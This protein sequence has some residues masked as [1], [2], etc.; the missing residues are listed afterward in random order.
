MLQTLLDPLG[1]LDLA[2]AR[3]ELDRA[4]L[5]HVHA[6]RIGRAA[7]LGIE[8]RRSGFGFLLDVLGGHGGR[9]FGHQ[10]RLG[11]GGLVVDLDAHVADHRD[12]AL[13]LLGVEDVVGQVVVD[14]GVRQVAALLAEHDQRL[15][16]ALARLDVGRR[17]LARRNLGVLAVAALL[18]RG[19]F[20]ALAG[21]PRG[22]LAGG[23]LARRRS[24]GRLR[25]CGGI[26]LGADLSGFA[27]AA[28]L[29]DLAAGAG[30]A[31]LTGLAGTLR[32]R[33]GPPWAL[34]PVFAAAF[35]ATVDFPAGLRAGGS[36]R[37]R[38]AARALG[39][40]RGPSCAGAFFAARFLAAGLPLPAAGD[41]RAGF[42]CFL[43]MIILV[44]YGA[45]G[46]WRTGGCA[47]PS[48]KAAP[49]Q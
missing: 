29:P 15:Q 22:D 16:A 43:T 13:D 14:L 33:W 12:D 17:Q 6:H 49:C 23:R 20:R 47:V 44:R 19:V 28:G 27:A 38:F 36:W 34:A 41:L 2:F 39:G 1:D 48:S 24:F 40:R 31:D 32:L 4:H 8:R 25:C 18:V 9:R 3:Q 35:A 46:W 5:A 26:R 30:L 7:E 45:A 42:A 37:R 10:Q 21:D 11:V